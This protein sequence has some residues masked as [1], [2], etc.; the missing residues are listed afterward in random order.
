MQNYDQDKEEKKLVK[1]QG[2]K[3]GVNLTADDD[4]IDLNQELE[5]ISIESKR[6]KVDEDM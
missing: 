4:H 1:Q 3:R 2:V 5:D 6:K